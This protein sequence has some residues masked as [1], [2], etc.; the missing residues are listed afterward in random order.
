MDTA[1]RRKLAGTILRQLVLVMVFAGLMSYAAGL[2]IQR[3]AG[4]HPLRQRV[5]DYQA[6]RTA[7]D[8]VFIGDSRTYCGIHPEHIDPLLGT[9]S[10]NLSTFAFWFPTQFAMIRDLGESL[11]GKQIVWTIGHQNFTPSPIRWAYPISFQVALQLL[12]T[13]IGTSGMLD[14]VM[15]SH[16]PLRLFAQRDVVRKGIEARLGIPVRVTPSPESA[17]PST[18]PTAAPM[19]TKPEYTPSLTQEQLEA[20]GK[21]ARERYDQDP[22]VAS[23]SPIYDGGRLTSLALHRKAG[24]YE[25]VELDYDYFR[26]QQRRITP[27]PIPEDKVHFSFAADPGQLRLFDLL[28]QEFSSHGATLIVNEVE[29][30]SFTYQSPA[31]R[32]AYRK[33]MREVIKPRVEKAGFRYVHIDLDRLNDDDFFDYNH[34]NSKGISK[35]SVMLS[36]ALRPMLEKAR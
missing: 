28:L 27:A 9:N 34:L 16:A 17:A 36:D 11:R 14:N 24:G 8:V 18:G 29:E 22:T 33:F 13:G 6:N 3:N 32:A 12:R 25:R 35:Y 5:L 2:Y 4:E 10:L 19:D 7:Y 15:F 31:I 1:G 26:W 23:I 20:L 30:A 21:V